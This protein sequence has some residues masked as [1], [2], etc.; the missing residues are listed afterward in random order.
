MAKDETIEFDA[1]KGKYIRTV[2]EEVDVDSEIS[3]VNIE[4]GNLQA[5]IDRL[6]E[7]KTGMEAKKAAFEAAKV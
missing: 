4:I 5:Q 3:Q 1:G 7:M 6:T 2:I